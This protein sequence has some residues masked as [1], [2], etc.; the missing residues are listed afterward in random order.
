MVGTTCQNLPPLHRPPSPSSSWSLPLKSCFLHMQRARAQELCKVKQKHSGPE[1]EGQASA[2]W[3]GVAQQGCASECGPIVSPGPGTA[4]PQQ[5]KL[6]VHSVSSWPGGS[7]KGPY[8]H[9]V[10]NKVTA[11]DRALS[12]KVCCFLP[13]VPLLGVSSLTIFVL[14]FTPGLPWVSA[15]DLPGA[16]TEEGGRGHSPV[17]VRDP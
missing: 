11:S 4:S 5:T 16:L 14:P 8:L 7:Q 12:P 17:T 9:T 1:S 15:T 2:P 6:S 3:E 13:L 10:P